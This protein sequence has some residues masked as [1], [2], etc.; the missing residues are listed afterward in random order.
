MDAGRLVPGRQV[1]LAFASDA[2]HATLQLNLDALRLQ[3]WREPVNLRRLRR[4]GNVQGRKAAACETPNARREL[5]SLLELLL[6]TIQLRKK[7]TGKQ[8]ELHACTLLLEVDDN[9]ARIDM[10]AREGFQEV[11]TPACGP[12]F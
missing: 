5:D 2:E 9:D 12:M 10:K 11:E 4:A 8:G 6:Q 7:V 3:A 1:G